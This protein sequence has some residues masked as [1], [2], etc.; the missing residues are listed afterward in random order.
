MGNSPEIFNFINETSN[1][2]ENRRATNFRPVL[3]GDGMKSKDS[4]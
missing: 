1:A 4:R 3:S 2:D